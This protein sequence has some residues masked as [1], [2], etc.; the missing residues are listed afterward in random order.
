MSTITVLR[1]N[2]RAAT[3]RRSIDRSLAHLH[4]AVR[5]EVLTREETEVR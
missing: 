4:P 3:R 2:I 5:D 1:R